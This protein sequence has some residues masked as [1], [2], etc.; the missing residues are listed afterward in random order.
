MSVVKKL[1]DLGIAASLLGMSMIAV[2]TSGNLLRTFSLIPTPYT[3]DCLDAD[4][5]PPGWSRLRTNT[6]NLPANGNGGFLLTMQ[7]DTYAKLQLFA[8]FDSGGPY[9]WM[10]RRANQEWQDWK[11]FQFVT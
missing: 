4:E 10:R 9:L 2:D 8:Q 5:A 6:V 7:Y 3:A 1:S 11:K